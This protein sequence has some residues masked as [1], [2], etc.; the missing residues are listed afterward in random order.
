LDGKLRSLIFFFLTFFEKDESSPLGSRNHAGFYFIYIVYKMPRHTARERMLAKRRG[1]RRAAKARKNAKLGINPRSVVNVSKLAD[2]KAMGTLYYADTITIDAGVAAVS[3]HVF[4]ANSLFDPDVTGTGH[5]YLLRDTMAQLYESYRIVEC[6]IKVTPV[7]TTSTPGIPGFW[8]VFM[9]VNTSLDYSLSTAIIEA[10][11]DNKKTTWAL[12]NGITSV[13]YG[14]YDK[15]ITVTFDSA[16][17]LCPE[18][19][20][21]ITTMGVS[22]S[23]VDHTR[24]FQIWSGSI[25]GNNSAAADFL[26]QMK[27]KVEFCNPK[28]LAQ[29]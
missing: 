7:F 18:G 4:Q 26:V 29:S 24:Y 3:N 17:D 28:F 5:Q 12:H 27:A 9:D 1:A 13:V 20:N 22:P 2:A 14:N 19:Y 21:Q 10:Q 25:L 8:G 6:E 16:R 15:S 11:A 23:G